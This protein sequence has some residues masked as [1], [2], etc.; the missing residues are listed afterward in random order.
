MTQS[1]NRHIP[2]RLVSR[3]I[4]SFQLIVIVFVTI[5]VIGVR[6]KSKDF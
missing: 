2:W 5:D 1:Y 6:K 3:S 4:K